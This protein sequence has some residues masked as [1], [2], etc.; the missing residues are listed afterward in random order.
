MGDR[1]QP[2]AGELSRRRTAVRRP[3]PTDGPPVGPD[4]WFAEAVRQGLGAALDAAVLRAALA[5][6]ASLP[7]NTFLSLNVEPESLLDPMV[8]RVFSREASLGGLV[9][10]VTEH[11]ALG[12]PRAV[13]PALERLNLPVIVTDDIGMLLGT[14]PVPRLLPHLAE[15]AG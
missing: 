6:R 14:V 1:S 8:M 7:R 2:C 9:V 4:R 5:H 15:A 12:D 10:E 13:V 11:R 3:A